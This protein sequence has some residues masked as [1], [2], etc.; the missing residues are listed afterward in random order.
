MSYGVLGHVVWCGVVLYC[1]F[2]RAS[3]LVCQFSVTNIANIRSESSLKHLG[4]PK[5]EK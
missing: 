3:L 2:L 5:I 4:I 1:V